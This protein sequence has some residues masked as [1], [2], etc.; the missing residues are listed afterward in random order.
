MLD[1]APDWTGGID[2]FVATANAWL[3]QLLPEDRAARPKDEVNARLVRHYTTVGLLPLPRRE[4][5]EARYGRLHL[6][7]LLALRRLMADGL[8]GKALY[9]TLSGQDE[10]GLAQLAQEGATGEAASGPPSDALAY[11]QNLKAQAKRPRPVAP[12]PTFFHAAPVPELQ[13]RRQRPSRVEATPL[14]RVTPQP[15]L[16]LTLGPDF[17]APQSE[18]EWTRLLRQVRRAVD[19]AGQATSE[20]Q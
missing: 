20:R 11:L 8:S 10:T 17:T 1:I 15:G 12:L 16:E 2:E 6:L 9:S 4:G 5:R 19:A 13:P 3:T 7:Q 14:V 18:E